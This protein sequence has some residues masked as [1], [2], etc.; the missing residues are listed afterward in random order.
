MKSPQ[1]LNRK[2]LESYIVDL[3]YNQNKTYKDIQGL[4]RKSFRDIKSILDKV[5]PKDS[6]T[7]VESISSK[8]YQ[9]FEEG[10][11][12]I[13]VAIA[14]NL[15]EKDVS[16]LYKEYWTM[17]EPYE[18]QRV[19]RE[20]GSSVWTLSELH[21]RMKAEDITLEQVKYII[22]TSTKLERRITELEVEKARLEA[23]NQYAALLYDYF[24]HV[25]HEDAKIIEANDYVIT[26]QKWE[27]EELKKEKS[28]LE[29]ELSD[30]MVE[31]IEN[32]NNPASTSSSQVPNLNLQNLGPNC[33]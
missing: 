22:R 7:E 25:K 18:L 24:T 9:M 12:P 6:I 19:F 1:D 14:L 17:K 30:I 3:F 11:S 21:R 5:R 27:I 15:R 10:K 4:T 28:N 33:Q 23:A 20:L 32:Q 8:A 31:C 29:K 26:K 16:D 13:Q 2:E